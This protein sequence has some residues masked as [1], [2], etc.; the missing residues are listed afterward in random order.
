[1]I[2]ATK[3]FLA[4]LIPTVMGLVL[5]T[6]LERNRPRLSGGEKLALSFPLGSGLITFYMFYL[7]IMRVKFNLLTVSLIIWPFLFWGIRFTIQK[8]FRDWI[9]FTAP[10]LFK[11]L[12]NWQKILTILLLVLLLIKIILVLF[13]IL[14]APTYF[15]DSVSFWNLKGKGYWEQTGIVWDK[16][17]PDFMGGANP[18]YPNGI[19][20]FKCWVALWA[21]EWNES[22][23][24][25]DTLIIFIC[26]GIFF[27]CQMK[28]LLSPLPSFIFSYLLLS[29]PLVTFHA[30]F[31]QF[32][33]MV[34]FYLFAGIASLYR[35]ITEKSSLYFI[36]SAMLFAVS[37]STKDEMVALFVAVAIPV[38]IIY[39]VTQ[40]S[41]IFELLKNTLLFLSISIIPN[42]PW[43]TVKRIYDLQL[44]F[45]AGGRVIEFHPEAFKLL[46]F[47]FFNTGNYNILWLGFF[48]VLIWTIP[49]A[50]KSDLKYLLLTL[51]LSL[52]VSLGVFIF[53]PFFEYLRIGTTINR[54]MLMVIPL[55][56][57]YFGV[58]VATLGKVLITEA[59]DIK[60][61]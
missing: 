39:Q 28:R 25:L 58:A 16:N 40:R 17:S 31:A 12:R 7:G 5:L 61:G 14:S 37:L 18:H 29:V 15:D 30:A 35:W 43:F 48:A 1:M 38:I 2:I 22:V 52:G 21:G 24:N 54:A 32:D 27:Y 60:G 50:L 49:I 46:A 34:G 11:G 26:L 42:L 4:Y 19:P 56:I 59:Q 33:L 23:V 47:Y 9:H 8:G 3:I 13:V 53:T 10:V 51:A 36:I 44:G 41:S 20:L 57:F 6:F 45:G 55:M